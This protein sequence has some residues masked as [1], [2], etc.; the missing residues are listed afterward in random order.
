ML[1]HDELLHTQAGYEFYDQESVFAAT[2][3]VYYRIF[4][5]WQETT[6][7]QQM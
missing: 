4:R 7:C 3:L 5:T 6:P 2:P 1:Q